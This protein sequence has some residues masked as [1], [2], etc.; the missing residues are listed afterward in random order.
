[1]RLNQFKKLALPAILLFLGFS[2]LLNVVLYSQLRKY[3]TLLYAVELDPLDLAYFQ[4][5]SKLEKP[6]KKLFSLEIRAPLNGLPQK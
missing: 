4:D 6:D 2:V 3:Y 1:M 5:F